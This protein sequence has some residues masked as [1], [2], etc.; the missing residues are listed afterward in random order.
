MRHGLRGS[1]L[2]KNCAYIEKVVNALRR[3]VEE[4]LLSVKGEISLGD[5]ATINTILK[6]ER[7]GSLASRWLRLEADSLSPGDR[8]KFSEAIAKASDNRDKAIARLQLDRDSNENI[9]EALYSKPQP[10]IK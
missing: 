8:L 2:P 6:W 1:K 7:H 9:L 4:A 5:A 3:N 10:A